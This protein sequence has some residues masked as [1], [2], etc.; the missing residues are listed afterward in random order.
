MLKGKHFHCPVNG[1]DC[2]Y[3]KDREIIE[4]VEEFHLCTIGT[5]IEEC[6]DFFSMWDG[7]DSEDYTDYVDED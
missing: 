6:D 3:Y 7:Y 2:P 4:G 1:W 5:P